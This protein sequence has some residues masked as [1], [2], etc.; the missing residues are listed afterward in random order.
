MEI[1]ATHHVAVFTENFSA[2]ETFYTETL[3]LPVTRRWDDAGIIFID[4][5]ST[6]IELIDREN[7]ARSR[8]QRG[9]F[10][11]LALHVADVDTAVAEL[12]EKGIIIT[13]GP[14]NFKE[15][16]VAFFADPDGN[17][18]ELVEDPRS[19]ETDDQ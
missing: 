18:L 3:G 9:G 11:H 4:V 2:L 5:G 14:R 8:A 15:V 19:A 16:R 17:V 6:K 10:D 13:N 12:Q 1:R 7:D